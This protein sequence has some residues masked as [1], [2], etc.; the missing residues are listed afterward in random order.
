[1]V[2]LTRRFIRETTPNH[3]LVGADLELYNPIFNK[4]LSFA[5][6]QTSDVFSNSKIRGVVNVSWRDLYHITPSG[7]DG[8]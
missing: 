7:L 6:A 1:M 8:G 5:L 2:Q 3:Q 4:N